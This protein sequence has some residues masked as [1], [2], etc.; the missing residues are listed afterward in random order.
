[1]FGNIK[2]R[3]YWTNVHQICTQYSQI[4]TDERFKIR[5]PIL[6]SVSECQGYEI[7]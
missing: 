1:M 4:I 7:R 3:S 6:Q 5:I 2:L